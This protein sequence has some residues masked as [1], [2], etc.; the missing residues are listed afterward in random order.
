M[1]AVVALSTLLLIVSATV[2]WHHR[3]PDPRSAL[4]VA[5][6]LARESSS[7]AASDGH[8]VIT[9]LDVQNA[10]NDFTAGPDPDVAFDVGIRN[11]HLVVVNVGKTHACIFVGRKPGADPRAGYCPSDVPFN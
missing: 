3:Q 6:F 1:K 2:S 7:V 5:T 11:V 4:G 10:I 9:A 8:R